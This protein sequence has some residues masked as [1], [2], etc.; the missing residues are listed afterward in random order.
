M[1][2][3][4]GSWPYAFCKVAGA[5]SSAARLTASGRCPLKKS[6]CWGTPASGPANALNST[7]TPTVR[8]TDPVAGAAGVG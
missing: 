5:S 3:A 7:L 4:A 1:R 6:T 8:L 2:Q